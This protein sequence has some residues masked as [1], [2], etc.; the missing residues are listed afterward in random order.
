MNLQELLK[1]TKVKNTI[2][3]T[4]TVKDKIAIF[5]ENEFTFLIRT[6]LEDGNYLKEFLRDGLIKEGEFVNNH[7]GLKPIKDIGSIKLNQIEI[8]KD[9][10]LFLDKKILDYRFE[11]V[12][13]EPNRLYSTCGTRL[14]LKEVEFDLKEKINLST[15]L[16]KFLSLMK[17]DIKIQITELGIIY[18]GFEFMV[19]DKAIE[20]SYLDV[21]NVLRKEHSFSFTVKGKNLVKE[22][23][24]LSKVFTSFS[25]IEE[26]QKLYLVAENIEE[27]IQVK[28]Y[29]NDFPIKKVKGHIINFKLDNIKPILPLLNQENLK[30]SF[31][32]NKNR[33]VLIGN[34]IILTTAHSEQ[35]N[36]ECYE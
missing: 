17:S 26:Q 7:N 22:V 35:G 6:D 8:L 2:L 33:Y 18:K 32:E 11:R 10:V 12:H 4:V 21:D 28:K 16:V 19:L 9:A 5:N 24:S 14:Y 30:F 1:K 15:E 34:S 27:E 25:L 36:F 23:K 29:I 3:P 31:G 20:D 13:I